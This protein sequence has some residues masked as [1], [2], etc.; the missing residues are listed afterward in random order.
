[1][2]S[3]STSMRLC[4]P[5]IVSEDNLVSNPLHRPLSC[6]FPALSVWARNFPLDPSLTMSCSLASALPGTGGSQGHPE[7][8]STAWSDE[9]LWKCLEGLGGSRGV[10]LGG[11]WSLPGSAKNKWKGGQLAFVGVPL[12]PSA[13]SMSLGSKD[14]GWINAGYRPPVSC[15]SSQNCT[16]KEKLSTCRQ[17]TGR[18]VSLIYFLLTFRGGGRERGRGG[19]EGEGEGENR[20]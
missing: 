6:H 18:S 16:I 8:V 14:T 17:N 19:R 1:M 2:S 13:V 11:S 5:C 15:T 3:E 4:P 12:S 7:A 20:A 9:L 10:F